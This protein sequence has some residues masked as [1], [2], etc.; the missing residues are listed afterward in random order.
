MSNLNNIMPFS[1]FDSFTGT[2]EELNT[3]LEAEMVEVRKKVEEMNTTK[4]TLEEQ[5]MEAKKKWKKSQNLY[6][7]YDISKFETKARIDLLFYEHLCENLEEINHMEDLI[8]DYY[9]T[10]KN[11]YEMINIAPRSHKMLNTSILTESKNT[12][13]EIFSNIVSQYL[14]ENYYK[15]P[16]EKRKEKFLEESKDYA[17]FLIGKGL[18]SDESIKLAVKACLMEN[19]IGNIAI[20]K[21]IQKRIKF[22]CED[23]DYGLVFDQERLKNLWE[24]FDQQTKTMSHIFAAAI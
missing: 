23:K 13:D 7:Q 2:Q 3:L 6:E 1:P 15:I 14:Q 20:P 22:L 24:K 17:A 11:L 4:K 18:D 10:A 19:L 16:P 9:K 12:Q 8:S 5:T 21:S